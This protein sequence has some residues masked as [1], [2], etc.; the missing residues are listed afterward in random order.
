MI[1][2]ILFSQQVFAQV[3]DDFG[4]AEIHNNPTW[5]GNDAKFSVYGNELRLSAPAVNDIA[6]LST[7]SSSINNA[8]WQFLVRMDFNPSSTNFSRA[9]LVSS[10][11]DLTGAT[12]GYFVMIGGTADEVSLYRQDGVTRTR[13]IDGADGTLNLSTVTVKVRVT[14]D[15]AGNWTLFSD[16][17]NTGTFTQE[18]IAADT[19]HLVSSYFGVY[20]EYTSTRSDKFYFDDISVVGDPF[21]DNVAPSVNAVEVVSSNELKLTFSEQIDS[22]SAVMPENYL[23]ADHGTA[24][25]VLLSNTGNEITLQFP[26]SFPNGIE[27]NLVVENVNDLYGN[28]INSINQSFMFFQ[29]ARVVKRDVIV[30]EFFADYS[31]VIGLPEGEF[32]EIYNRS[33]NPIQLENWRVTD[34]SSVGFFPDK[35]LLPG[36]YL[37]VTASSTESSFASFGP[38][39]GLSNFPTLNNSAD[40]I[41]LKDPNDLVIDSVNYSSAWYGDPDKSQGGW[42]VERINKE[43]ECR[44]S[45]NWR[46]SIATMG[47]T[48]GAENSVHNNEADTVPPAIVSV[49]H[50]QANEFAIEFTEKLDEILPEI[51][52]IFISPALTI[53]SIFYSNSTFR[54]IVI[55]FQENIP[56][57][58]SHLITFEAL[59]DCPGNEID[60]PISAWLYYDDTPPAI[61]EIQTLSDT[62]VLVR[63]SESIDTTETLAG[64]LIE[65]HALEHFDFADSAV[66][67]FSGTPFQN[68]QTQS[69]HIEGIHDIND[70]A[71]EQDTSFLYFKPSPVSNRDI[72]ITEIFADPSPVVGLPEVEFVEIYNRSHNPINVDQWIFTDLSSLTTL[73]SD[74]LLPGDYAVICSKTS[75]TAF[76]ETSKVIG[77]GNF[78][79]LNNNGEVLVLRDS[80]GKMIDSVFYSSLWY[81]DIDK[82]EGGWTLEVIDPD[83]VCLGADNWIASTDSTGGTPGQVNSVY[84]VI[85]DVEGPQISNLRADSS[86][87]VVM[88]NEKLGKV[89]PSP[90]QI[91]VSPSLIIDSAYFHNNHRELNLL[92]PVAPQKDRTYHFQFLNFQDCPGNVSDTLHAYL[93]YDTIPPTIRSITIS[94]DHALQ[95]LFS[96]RIDQQQT[97][98]SSTFVL[99]DSLEPVSITPA[100]SSVM[101]QFSSSFAN[102]Y[103]HT[104]SISQVPDINGNEFSA[105]TSFTYFVPSNVA[106]HDVI[107]TE[108]FPDPSPLVGLPPTEFIELLN[109]SEN[110]VDLGMLKFTDKSSTAS[111]PQWIL[112][113]GEYITV[114]SKESALNFQEN[115]V[116]GV[117]N[118]P[119]LGNNQDTIVLHNS[120]GVVLDSLVYT[121]EWYRD[122]DKQAGGWSL[123]RIDVNNFCEI[124]Q[125]WMASM[126]VTGGTPGHVNSVDSVLN[127]VEGP[128]IKTLRT[129]TTDEVLIEFDEPLTYVPLLS[130]IMIEPALGIDSIFFGDWDKSVVSILLS[131]NIRDGKTYVIRV[132]DAQDCEGNI[133]SEEHGLGYLNYDTIPP[134]VIST[135]A[136]TDSTVTLVYSSGTDAQSA[137]NI[138]NYSISEIN[139]LPISVTFVND[140]ATLTFENQFTN[141]KNYSLLIV[142]ITDINGNRADIGTDFR[143]FNPMPVAY[144]DVIINE[145]FPDP[146]PPIGL[147]EYEFVELYNRSPNP[148]DLTDWI[149]S[150]KSTEGKLTAHI[151]LPDEYVILCPS[152]AI[153]LFPPSARVIGVS[154]FPSLNNSSD[155]LILKDNNHEIIDSLIYAS[156]WYADEDKRAGGWTLERINPDDICRQDENWHASVDSNG[157]TP[158]EINSVYNASPDV[159][160][161]ILAGLSMPDSSTVVL[162]FDESLDLNSPVTFIITP[163]IDIASKTIQQKSVTI[164]LERRVEE[165]RMYKVEVQNLFDCPGNKIDSTT[166]HVYI[167]Y[168]TVAPSLSALHIVSEKSVRLNFTERLDEIETVKTVNYQIDDYE[169]VNVSLLS[170]SSVQVEFSKPFANGVVTNLHIQNMLDI[171][172][173]S[174]NAS[175]DFIYFQSAP[176]LYKDIVVSEL[177][178]DPAPVVGLPEAEYVELFNRSSNPV[179]LANWVI[180]DGSISGSLPSYI[181]LPQEYVL[182]C[183]LA[184]LELFLEYE[185]VL[186][187]SDF[188]SLN[189]AS[190]FVKMIDPTGAVIDSISYTDEWYGHADYADGGYS[191][192]IIDPDNV[193]A[194]PKNWAASEDDNGGTPGKL[195]SI[196]AEML[197]VHGPEIT[198]AYAFDAFKVIVN[199]NEKLD[200]N[201]PPIASFDLSPTKEIVS[202]AFFD[203][204]LSALILQLSEPL[205]TGVLYSVT[206]DDTYD[207]AGNLINES[208]NSATFALPQHA[209]RND[210]VINEI[211]FNPRTGGPDFVELYNPGSKYVNFK[212]WSFV[213]VT[214]TG[215]VNH[216]KLIESDLVIGPGAFVVFSPDPDNLANEYPQGDASVFVQATLPSLNDDEGKI[217]LI[218]ITGNPIDQLHYSDKM[219]SVFLNETEGVSLERIYANESSSK[220]DNWQSA[221]TASG[222]ATPGIKNSNARAGF[223]NDK[224]TITVSPQVFQPNGNQESFAEIRYKFEKGGQIGNVRVHDAQGRLIKTLAE[225]EMLAVEGFVRWNG[226][227]ENG[228]KARIGYYMIWFEVFDAYGNM[229]VFKE[230]VAIAGQF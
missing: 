86:M 44:E 96:E 226:D 204:S 64:I 73:P 206:V 216:Q 5:R 63:F 69:L 93:N 163:E 147:P 145:F 181:L 143:H 137:S 66:T 21:V 211:L 218:D 219:H 27:S 138:D 62:S 48:P 180:S 94:S 131:E 155:T 72:I 60:Q 111:F 198:D 14:R 215:F 36:D 92:L 176:I 16:V 179:Q 201:V 80:S 43:D 19:T 174:R 116:V 3:A 142:G 146:A 214:D 109:R 127:D 209:K 103:H 124:A 9:Y 227:E 121:N 224:S 187:V 59:R 115:R 7:A 91:I 167:N 15:D 54:E 1:V 183:N 133:I 197:D 70:N 79:T 202:V 120:D 152:S 4:D 101:L 207:C 10:A 190:D 196:D 149:I 123:E 82:K 98:N 184:S 23:I 228:S 164:F 107:I 95:I 178:A 74:I 49:A 225:N 22:A 160:G 173:N 42:T 104:L 26:F 31:P 177:M 32:F 110:P 213:N 205:D 71:M 200:N 171:N 114:C 158:G 84:R 117:V 28:T 217:A 189:N 212:D 75:A 129:E 108:I 47:G 119:T 88:F 29:A 33:E 57:G 172:G 6:Y 38:V 18:G 221:S 112:L 170:K 55:L 222:F 87:I 20:C 65:G 191:L 203:Q 97:I 53:D 51:T 56:I 220:E 68:G 130:Q 35:I 165:G 25:Q 100:D 122:I 186:G 223:E 89:L 39:V 168:D 154:A 175:V 153:D 210:I 157:G 182:L 30:T 37:I 50:V 230:R 140:T 40:L 41:L 188:P 90:D 148:I 128:R 52:D 118:F 132:T 83:D 194:G 139:A 135:H 46:A 102:G 77:V 105:D 81:K 192:E 144:R 45:E 85:H 185:N 136:P 58:K 11:D 13:I 17:G 99:A 76:A 2:N 67:L 125:N 161:P 78:P 169:V 151:L 208:E 199:T 195:N 8:T 126:N 61:T 134:S 34:G 156:D 150:D 193:C 162:S 166:A 106:L 24:N 113:P 229:K 159:D 141:G 12:D